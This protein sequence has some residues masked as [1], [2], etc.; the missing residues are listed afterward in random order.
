MS[1]E[2]K[3]PA[4]GAD[5]SES[6]ERCP[7]CKLE[8]G[9]QDLLEPDIKK[10]SNDLVSLFK[11]NDIMEAQMLRTILED[12]KIPCFVSEGGMSSVLGASTPSSI[13]FARFRILVPASYAKKAVQ[14]LAAHKKWSRDE[15]SRYLSMLDELEEYS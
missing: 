1:E 9:F 6:D 11:L 8:F 15:L 12:E 4:C 7:Q 14:A 10:V 13:S 5:I 2:I 3:C